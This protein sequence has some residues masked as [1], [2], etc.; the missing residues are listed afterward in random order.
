MKRVYLAK[1]N[2]ANP[3]LVSAV[4][5]TLSK[6][7]IE[8]VEFTGGE[9]S[10]ELLLSCDELYVIPDLSEAK[11]DDCN[12]YWSVPIGK[13]L[14]E[15]VQAFSKAHKHNDMFIVTDY[16]NIDGVGG[17]YYDEDSDYFYSME[18][19]N[20][21]DYI[22][23]AYFTVNTKNMDVVPWELYDF[24]LES[25][26]IKDTSWISDVMSQMNDDYKT[27]KGNDTIQNWERK[28][29]NKKFMVL[30]AKK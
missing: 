28:A 14:Y 25:N 27:W 13:G 11:Q 29:N 26:D 6:F 30:L 1:S 4:R 8:L 9:Y 3:N 15:Q 21:N 12:N 7:D 24:V 2:R 16:D 20:E 10:H 5:Q 23:Y 19:E 22:T 17:V 18:V